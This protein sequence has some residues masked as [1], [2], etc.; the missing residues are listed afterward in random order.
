[1]AGAPV[2]FFYLGN[3]DSIM[4]GQKRGFL[5]VAAAIFLFSPFCAAVSSQQQVLDLAAT[6]VQSLV[7]VT[8]A[9]D[10][11]PFVPYQ[12]NAANITVSLAL[13]PG[14]Y[15]PLT[16]DELTVYVSLWPKKNGSLMYFRNGSV[17]GSAY[18]LALTCVLT[19]GACGSGSAT[20]RTVE[21]FFNAPS[22]KMLVGDGLVVNASLFPLFPSLKAGALM[23]ASQEFLQQ[24]AII[25]E[26]AGSI[27]N[28]TQSLLAKADAAK[29]NDPELHNRT[30]KLLSEASA[31]ALSAREALSRGDIGA[32]GAEVKKAEDALRQATAA[33]AELAALPKESAAA[34]ATL[35]AVPQAQ[36][37]AQNSGQPSGAAGWFTA[38][39]GSPIPFVILIVLGFALVVYFSE[40][41]GGSGPSKG[42]SSL[43]RGFRK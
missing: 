28:S 17:R 18:Y 11:V 20:E 3:V 15:R 32:A 33:A 19:D 24:A 9:L 13:P 40:G 35:S 30:V 27:L 6:E 31:F 29:A 22:E 1:M 42:Q 7:K 43:E 14:A 4:A 23:I 41:G 10:F 25:E 26:L 12:E 5:P 8:G 38:F 21:I 37:E 2:G 34:T 36:A 16:A 39:T